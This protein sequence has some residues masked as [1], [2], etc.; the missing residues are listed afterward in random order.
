VVGAVAPGSPAA[1][2]GL[3][4]GD[5]VL[6]VEGRDAR[7]PETFFEEVLMSP[8][9]VR[10]VTVE[11][12]GERL[13]VSLN[14]GS[15]PTYRLG[16]PG[17]DLLREDSEAPVVDLVSPGEPAETAGISPGDRVVEA[18]GRPMAGELDLR[19]L[20]QASPGRRVALTLE[21]DGRRR[22]VEV[23]PRDVGGSGRIG[24]AFR[25]AGLVHREL[26]VGEALREAWRQ[27]VQL[28]KTLFVTLDRLFRG[29]ISVRAFS[30]PLE[31]ARYS[32]QA[33]RG[34]ETFLS[35]L[36][37]ISL[38]LGI[39]NL[40]PIPVLDGGHILML[41]IEAVMRRDLSDR[42]KERVM[43]VG[44]FFLLGFFVLVMYFDADKSNLFK[45][46]KDFFVQ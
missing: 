41:G 30:G 7:L 33:V 24:V 6:A 45:S 43:Q 15:D 32:R 10:K 16:S 9:T 36:A 19:A 37:F 35:F 4:R 27:N 20:L 8:D 39:L 3:L 18:D 13:E 28:S 26:G 42:V 40:L 31:I 1:R 17:I 12:G 22:T 5:R 21:R 14:T 23:V 44:F 34:L 46:I 11:R 2:A 38:Q 29:D 25:A